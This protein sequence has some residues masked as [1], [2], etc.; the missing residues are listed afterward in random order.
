MVDIKQILKDSP[1]KRIAFYFLFLLVIIAVLADVIANKKPLWAVVNGKNYF[2]AFSSKKII[3]GNA[4]LNPDFIDW[5][6]FD[7]EKKVFAP[8]TYSSHESDFNNLYSSPF[9]EQY[10]YAH[11][12]MP[13]RYRHIAGTGKRGEDVMAGIIYGTRISLSTG[14]LSMLLASLIGIV[15]GISAAW[16][17]NNKLR[18]HPLTLAASLLLVVPAWFYAFTLRRFILYDALQQ[19]ALYYAWQLLISFVVFSAVIYFPVKLIQRFTKHDYY[20]K[21]QNTE[22]QTRYIY[23]PLDSLLSRFIEIFVSLPRLILILTFATIARPSITNLILIFGLTMWTDIARLV[24]AETLRIKHE[25]YIL[26]ALA[27]GC[28][29]W[30]IL[31]RH[32]L[33]NLRHVIF[34]A[35]VFGLAQVILAESALSFL[36]IGI[37]PETVSWGTLLASGRENIQAWWLVVLPVL[38]LFIT[39]ASLNVAAKK[40]IS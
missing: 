18:M 4:S 16:F 1:K 7:C 20:F 39:V 35:F 24:R 38:M 2:P 23:I 5:K 8:I 12:A 15:T 14:F 10:I 13:F 9:D 21:S 28:S 30:R 32:V 33:P 31:L 19:S 26:S 27:A 22:H 29:T 25:T 3:T 17:G 34:A 11:K 40:K 36:G 6:T 37:S